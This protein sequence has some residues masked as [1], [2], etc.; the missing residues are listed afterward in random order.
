MSTTLCKHN[1]VY[2][3]FL[4]SSTKQKSRQ[5]FKP[6]FKLPA[7][8]CNLFHRMNI[9]LYKNIKLQQK[10]W[11]IEIISVYIGIQKQVWNHFEMSH[12]GHTRWKEIKN[13][14]LIFLFSIEIQFTFFRNNFM[15]YFPSAFRFGL[16][17]S[18]F[19]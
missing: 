5:Q 12:P 2:I 19:I 10:H 9:K 13:R 11:N 7:K 6:R 17:I 15:Y 14:I 3:F 8:V 4:Q 1:F 16:A 18:I